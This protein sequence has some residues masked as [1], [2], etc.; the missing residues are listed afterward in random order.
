MLGFHMLTSFARQPR[1]SQQFKQNLDT[2]KTTKLAVRLFGLSF[3]ILSSAMFSGCAPM[4]RTSKYMTA[5]TGVPA[6]PPSGKVLVC[7]HRPQG[8]WQGL[9]MNGGSG[10]YTSIWDGTKFIADLGNE[11]SVAYVCEPGIHYFLSESPF[12]Q[13][14]IEAQLLP[15]KTYDLWIHSYKLM[16]LKQDT[17]SRK[18]VAKWT[19]KNRWV[20][21]TPAA[22]TYEQRKQ[23]Q[24]R[25]MLEQF[26]FGQRHDK[27]Q[28][29][30]ADDHR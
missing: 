12:L 24:V 11:Q 7:I 28:H 27:L 5:S 3:F 30:A 16:P 14:C 1:L 4:A 2:M 13:A 10:Y 8:A 21:P 29:L 17:K 15:D 19:Q 18:L 22:A 20:A 6:A 23:D 25:Q 26:T 9:A